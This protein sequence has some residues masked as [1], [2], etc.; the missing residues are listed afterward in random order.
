MTIGDNKAHRRQRRMLTPM[1]K[2]V[3]DARREGSMT[4]EKFPI[5][6]RVFLRACAFGESGAVLVETPDARPSSAPANEKEADCFRCDGR[7]QHTKGTR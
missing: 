2:P 1:R 4:V 5:G 7:G 6:A 3:A